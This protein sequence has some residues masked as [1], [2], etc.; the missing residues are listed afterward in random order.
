MLSLFRTNQFIANVLLV[1]YV[2]LLRFS[3]FIVSTEI[4]YSNP[5]YF[6]QVFYDLIGSSSTIHAV[7]SMIILTI[8]ALM[9]NVIFAKYRISRSVSL[10]PGV[11]YVLICSLFPDFLLLSPLLLANTFLIFAIF[12][13][14]D[15]YKNNRPYPKIFNAGLWI[16]ISVLFYFSMIV[17]VLAA[18]V[19]FII[20]RAINIKEQVAFILGLFTPFWLV[21]VYNFFF[22]TYDNFWNN[23]FSNN[24][25]FFNWN[26]G[27]ELADIIQIGI[28][29]LLMVIA[30]FSYRT[31]TIKI[32]IRSQKYIDIIYWFAGFSILSLA[33]QAG[34]KPDHLLIISVPL[35]F[36]I[37]MSFLYMNKKI[38]EALHLI[39]LAGVMIYAFKP[40]WLNT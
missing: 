16:G 6:S 39:I 27:F 35:A 8:N 26:A 14:F 17:F 9:I 29:L 23:T 40:I 13:L 33:L 2:I 1:F 25:A 3:S 32:S 18:F 21:G 12:E 38:A 34:I 11:F 15:I 7:L 37:S 24:I 10:F 30:I 19:G 28:L 36:L 20:L 22:D 4:N 5:G 31:Y